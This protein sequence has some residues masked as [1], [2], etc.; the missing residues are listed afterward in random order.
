MTTMIDTEIRHFAP[1][2]AAYWPAQRDGFA[3]IAAVENLLN[4]EIYFDQEIDNQLHGELHSW[5]QSKIDRH[6]A[7]LT[8]EIDRLVNHAARGHA[9]LILRAQQRTDATAQRIFAAYRDLTETG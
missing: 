2:E 4:Y 3:A 9:I 8:A 7:A 6:V 5:P 1:H